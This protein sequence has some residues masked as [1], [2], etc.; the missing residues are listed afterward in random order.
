MFWRRSREKARK[1][2]VSGQALDAIRVQDYDEANRAMVSMQQCALYGTGGIKQSILALREQAGSA[3]AALKKLAASGLGDEV[4][5]YLYTFAG[6]GVY[7]NQETLRE[8]S[9][10]LL[11]PLDDFERECLKRIPIGFIPVTGFETTQSVID[12]GKCYILV[13]SGLRGFLHSTNK[14][15]C[16]RM[17]IDENSSPPTDYETYLS[18]MCSC[19]RHA[20]EEERGP[21]LPLSSL[22][23][24][25]AFLMAF[26]SRG[27][28]LFVLAHEYGHFL[29]GHLSPKCLWAPAASEVVRNAI[30]TDAFS[31]KSE[32]EAARSLLDEIGDI[33]DTSALPL[34]TQEKIAHSLQIKA[35]EMEADKE[36]ALLAIR[37][38]KNLFHSHEAASTVVAGIDSFFSLIDLIERVLSGERDAQRHIYLQLVGPSS[39]PAALHRRNMLQEIV[40]SELDENTKNLASDFRRIASM[41]A[42]D[43]LSGEYGSFD[44]LARR[45]PPLS[46]DK[47]SSAR[48][49]AA[50]WLR[51]LAH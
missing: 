20:F 48:G 19:I 17:R 28:D 10:S 34:Q 27:Q 8:I 38:I 5:E 42:D 9:D 6:G 29:A 13:N 36:G 43:I 46:S 18:L 22:D 40:G 14:L 23:K 26:L 24:R 49:G 47:W 12:R 15:I 1:K 25:M 30:E 21:T 7:D 16:S 50:E 2:K 4:A 11:A 32:V 31:V 39:H 37:A 51:T 35:E 33:S 45:A 44:A 41:T 3:D